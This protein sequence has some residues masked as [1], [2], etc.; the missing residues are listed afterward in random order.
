MPR[1]RHAAG[2]LI[3]CLA[4]AIAQSPDPAPNFR[5]DTKVIQVPVSVTD[6]RGQSVE[7]LTVGDFQLLDNGIPRQIALDVFDGGAAPISLAIAIQTA[8]IST[9]A[10]AKIRRIGGMIQPLVIGRRG[11]A[12]VVAF[13]SQIRWLQDFTSESAPIQSAI[14]GLQ[15][16]PGTE[17]RMF[18][19][20]ARISDRLRDRKGR[21]VLLLISEARDRGSEASFQQIMEEIGRHNIE[22]FAAHYSPYASNLIVSAGSQPASPAGLGFL[23]L[24]N[25]LTR[26][27]QVNAAQALTEA[28]GGADYP[29]LRQRGIEKAIEKLGVEVHSQYILSFPQRAESAPADSGMH[30]IDVSLPLRGNVRIRARRAFWPD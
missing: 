20:I 29:F 8:G 7:R 28:T 17:A 18:D 1:V 4:G 26:M 23:T 22:V 25:E 13:E 9:P 30:R 15:P 2:Y 14:D 27:G 5:A 21:R 10:I 6:Q 11:E 3:C 16:A 24:F 19:A 12:A